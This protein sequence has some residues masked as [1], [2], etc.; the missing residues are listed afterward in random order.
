MSDLVRPSC[1]SAAVQEWGYL[2][3]CVCLLRSRSG[4][5]KTFVWA[6]CGPRTELIR[7]SLGPNVVQVWAA[8][9]M[10]HVVL[11]SL[12]TGHSVILALSRIH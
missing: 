10:S 4:D 11:V 7:P 12:D 6:Q 1:G 2:G 5:S 9:I 8:S 3:L